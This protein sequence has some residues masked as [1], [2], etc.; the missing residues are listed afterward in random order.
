MEHGGCVL[1]RLVDMRFAGGSVAAAVLVVLCAMAGPAAASTAQLVDV[2]LPPY[3]KY[4][5]PGVPCLPGSAPALLYEAGPG[6]PNRV[7]LT[8]GRDELRISDPAAVISPGAGCSRIDR[9][10][11]RCSAEQGVTRVFVA[12]RG[13]ADTV[14]SGIEDRDS[15]FWGEVIVS[16]GRGNDVL[17]GG[18]SGEQLYAGSGA[19]VLRGRGGGDLLSDA[20]APDSLQSGDPSPFPSDEGSVAL[21]DSGRGR[22]FIEGGSGRGDV[23]S[24]EARRAGV[25]VDLAKPA[26]IGGARRER[27][28]VRGVE[29][30]RGGAGDDRLAGNG[31][32]NGLDGGDG[33][34]RIV[35]GRGNDF[36][37]GGRGRNVIVAGAGDDQMSGSYRP[38]DFGP[39][40]IFCG[41]GSDFVG[42]I[43]PSDFLNDDCERLEFNFLGEGGLFGGDAASLLPLRKGSPPSV[44][45]ATELW[46]YAMANPTGCQLSLELRVD[47][48]ATQ[49]GTAPTRGRLLGSASYTFSPDER[50]SVTLDVSPTGLEILRRHR[51]LRVLVSAREDPSHPPMGYLTVLRTP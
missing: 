50:K 30:A 4:N 21:A 12:T 49:G 40:R 16:G 31:R 14:R 2:V 9:H 24:Y 44:L 10:T 38:F 37:E 5:P 43:F 46:C 19:D 41:S 34:D 6:E 3:C 45:V 13:G 47:G 8:G 42:W 35:G 17:I 26:A 15:W 51:A 25:R 20:A 18:P 23:V 1:F 27:D 33:D 36:I 29:S 48:P 7:S 39:E 32:S 28:L 22:D 11:V